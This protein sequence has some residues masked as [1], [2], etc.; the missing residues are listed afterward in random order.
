MKTKCDRF[1]H[2]RTKF[3][4]R[5]TNRLLTVPY[6][7]VRSFRYT[8]SYCHGY[9]TEGAG[10]GDYSSIRGWGVRALPPRPPTPP[11]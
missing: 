3:G 1:V 6:F 5:R 7:F 4:R 8:A 2:Q 9:R 11:K 10:V